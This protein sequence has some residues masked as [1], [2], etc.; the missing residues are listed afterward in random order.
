MRNVL[1]SFLILSSL[2]MA[3][4]GHAHHGVSGQFD[5]SQQVTFKGSVTRVRL[6][7]PHAYIYFDVTMDN[8]DIVNHRCE[9]S[10]GSILKRKGWSADLFETGTVLEFNGSPDHDDPTTCYAQTITFED[11]RVLT[12]NGSVSDDGTFLTADGEVSVAVKIE[13]PTPELV[14]GADLSGNWIVPRDRATHAGLTGRPPRYDLTEKGR[15]EST[16]FTDDD[17]TRTNCKATNIIFDYGFD[18]M[19]NKFVQTNETLDIFYGFMDVERTIH[20]NGTFP[21]D[22]EPSLTG[23]SIGTWNG[24][25]LEVTTKGFAAGF[26]E[27]GGPRNRAVR[28]SDQMIIEEVFYIKDNGNLMREYTI[29]DPIYLASAQSHADEAVK[30]DDDFYP[31]E[32]DDLTNER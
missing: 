4:S 14:A 12:R 25:K 5:T 23:Y 8:G 19:I 3:T 21:D 16:N 28:H 11:G 1:F 32:C 9:L 2:A 22:I 27:I 26:L 30:S 6:V 31:Y 17:L 18:E 29:T 10:S 13:E 7:N 20:I 15:A 24:D